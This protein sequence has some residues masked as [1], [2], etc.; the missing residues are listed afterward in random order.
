MNTN[1]AKA[2]LLRRDGPVS[3]LVLNRPDHLNA[4]DDELADGLLGG[5]DLVGGDASCRCLVITGSGRGFCS[6]QALGGSVSAD[7]FAQEVG[8]LVRRRYVP[9]ITKIR[10]LPLPVVAAVNGAAAG[11]GFSLALAAD[12]RVAS[13]AAWFSCAFSGIGLVPDSGASFFLPRYVGLAKAIE[14]ALTG[15]RVGAAEAATLGLVTQVYPAETFSQDYST[16]AHHLAQGPTRAFALTKR[17]LSEAT[18]NSLSQQLELEA[19][20]QQ[21][22]AETDDFHEGLSAFR[23]KRAPQFVG[24]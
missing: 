22:A 23:N 10:E 9:I 17:A 5:L 11:A 7:A 20:L 16:L 14:M 8:A 24:H 15:R 12:L 18:D 13:E 1:G 4:I 2:V 19:V 21:E 3:E 6:G